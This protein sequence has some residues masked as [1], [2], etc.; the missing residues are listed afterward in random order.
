ME[1]AH[2][3]RQAPI[4]RFI[5]DF[6][7]H[8]RK[9]IIEVDGGQH[10]MPENIESDDKRTAFLEGEGYRVL[11]LWNNDVLS[12]TEGALTVIQNALEKLDG[13]C[14]PPEKSS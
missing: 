9:L 3:R 10:G 6:V 14:P 7:C 11:R 8:E 1:G 13:Q 5:V 12:N 2:F 4:G